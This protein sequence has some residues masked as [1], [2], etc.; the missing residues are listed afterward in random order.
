MVLLQHGLML[1]GPGARDVF[2]DLE[3][4]SV[5]VTV[6]FALSGLIVAEAVT[7]F[8]AGRP[9]AFLANRAL[10]VVPLY[11][12][13]LAGTVVL[14]A[15]LAQRGFLVPLDAPLLGSPLQP[16]VLLGGVLEI[17]PGMP[18]SRI[19]GQ[20]F[21]F[22]PFAWTLRVEFVFYLAAAA[23]CAVLAW[24]TWGR[25]LVRVMA[26]AAYVVFGAFLLN[27]ARGPLQLICMPFF[28]FGVGVFWRDRPGIASA[29]HLA[30]ASIGVLLAFP[31][32]RQ[33]GHPNLAFQLVLLA[34][35]YAAIFA[36]ARV[37]HL[38]R[39]W[40]YWDRRLGE[41]SYPIYISHG[42]VLTALA[43]LSAQR[44]G[45]PYAMALIGTLL[46]ATALHA[47]VELP[48]RTLRTRLRGAVV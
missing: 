3:L 17:L 26:G 44:G 12:V 24:R 11:L 47:T 43:S 31:H 35:L 15:W 46:L 27:G 16:R 10:R 20:A 48:L 45:V 13:A 41:L 18:A 19:S 2:Y 39:A 28:A 23:G 42:I 25:V 9:A 4:G 32:F 30:A 33:H 37:R 21:S 29:I 36:L 7:R 1:L 8:Y 38:P 6:F 40:R 34:L 22:I 5:A 14:D